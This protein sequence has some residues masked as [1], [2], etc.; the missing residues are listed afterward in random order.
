M[1]IPTIDPDELR[2]AEARAE[3][4][5]VAKDKAE[6]AGREARA[7]SVESDHR[8]R[9]QPP[10]AARLLEIREGTAAAEVSR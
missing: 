5:R 3:A 9:S 8:A 6:R 7:L 10:L 1:D 4:W 2:Q